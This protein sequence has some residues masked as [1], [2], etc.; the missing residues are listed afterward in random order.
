M[1]KVPF[2][3][4]L[5]LLLALLQLYEFAAERKFPKYSVLKSARFEKALEWKESFQKSH[6]SSTDSNGRAEKEKTRRKSLYRTKSGFQKALLPSKKQ[7]LK[8]TNPTFC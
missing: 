5:L 6:V 7:N 8:K 4:T 1:R 2:L 3:I